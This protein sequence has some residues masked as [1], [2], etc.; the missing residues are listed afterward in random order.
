M[1][2]DEFDTFLL[3]LD[4]VVY[5]GAEPI[6]S[7]VDAIERLRD[8]GKTVQFLTNNSRRPRTDLAAQLREDG[9]S[10]D[11]EDVVSSASATGDVLRERGYDSAFVVGTDGLEHE[12]H[13]QGFDVVTSDPDAVVVG[14]DTET[15]YRD[16]EFGARAIRH[17]AAFVAANVDSTFPTEEGIAPGTGAIVRA[18][19]VV[20]EEE[21]LVVGKPEVRMFEQALTSV[22]PDADAVMVGDTLQSDVLGARRAEIPSI[23]VTGYGVDDAPTEDTTVQPDAVVTDLAELFEP[24]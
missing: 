11:A 5:V 23:L 12:L 21:P 22:G 7:A 14:L 18:I 13:D 10:A 2:A 1:L 3:D 15:T 16:I 6:P 20:A 8:D 17:G 24:V 19:E 4:G 9:I